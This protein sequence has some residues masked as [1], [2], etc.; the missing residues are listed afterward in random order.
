LQGKRSG[1]NQT[2]NDSPFS[3]SLSI[4]AIKQ[5][6]GSL[7]SKKI[8]IHCDTGHPH[9]EAVRALE[10]RRLR[11]IFRDFPIERCEQVDGIQTGADPA[12]DSFE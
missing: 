2:Q 5:P 9:P 4:D 11:I 1:G 3:L 8:G 7:P 10:S 12:R 6:A